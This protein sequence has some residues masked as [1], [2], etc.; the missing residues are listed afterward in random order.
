[1]T[2]QQSPGAGRSSGHNPEV[3][4]GVPPRNTNFTGREE[5]LEKL[6]RGIAEEV[7]AVVPQA[8]HG[9][10]GV[11][12]TLLAAE[13]AYRYRGEY[14]LV[15]WIPADQ[16]VLVRSS[17]AQLAPHLGLPPFTLTGIEESARSVLDAL[18][19]GEP[20]SRWLLVFDNAD[21]PEDLNDILPRGP[22]HVL[23]TSR[24]HRWEGVVDTLPVEVFTRKESVAFLQKRVRQSITEA[25][26]TR[27]ADQ[28]GDLPL[29]LEQAGALMAETGMTVAEYIRLLGEHTRLVLSEGK[30]PEYPTSMSAAWALSVASVGEK[31]PE[32][33][34]VLRYCAYFSPDAIPRRVFSEAKPGLSPQLP[35]LIGNPLRVSKIIWELGRYALL[36]VDPGT[37]SIQVHRLI[38]A[39]V[40]DELLSDEK[41]K[42]RHDVHLLLAGAVPDDPE[43]L[44][45]WPKY[46]ELVGHIAPSGAIECT[47]ERLHTTALNMVRY[48]YLSGQYVAARSLDEEILTTWSERA[49]EDNIDVLRAYR[50]LAIIMRG[51]GEYAAA[52]QLNQETLKKLQRIPGSDAEEEALLLVNSIGA[53]LRANGDFP[54]AKTHDELSRAQHESAFGPDDV[55]TLRA[56]HNLALDYGMTSDYEGARDLH[57]E[58]YQR[59]AMAAA[60][61][62]RTFVLSAMTGTSRATRLCGDYRR[63]C[64]L[65]EDAYA[66][67]VREMGA[68]HPLTLRAAIELSVGRRRAADYD[69]AL[70]LAEAAYARLN[71]LYG[72]DNPDTMAAAICLAN[73]LRTRGDFT[74]AL[75]LAADSMPR[76]QDRFGSEHPY[77]H[78]CA[79]NLALLKRVTG[80]PANARKL[81]EEALAGLEAK[82]TRDHHFSLTVAT[83]LASDLAALGELEAAV[84]LG[85]GNLR[86]LRALFDLDHPIV[87]ASSVNLA[88]DLR[89]LGEE[90]EA[91]ELYADAMERYERTIGLDHPDAVVAAEGRHLD[92]DFDPP[93][94]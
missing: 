78:A 51:Q 5:L 48:L 35:G 90:K 32:A 27:L 39:L 20:Y 70:D 12:K 62:G 10:G 46:A 54:A 53:D 17:L 3:W 87:L 76:Y 45:S 50:H 15:W 80:E 14:D 93:P 4:G 92:F 84:R 60:P 56:I 68:D 8:L 31:L 77:C 89:A 25:D 61:T 43:D 88:V 81:D 13:Y 40:R 1:M 22:G 65:G 79:G 73:I 74:A 59:Q 86:R 16:P 66:Y 49:G 24:N 18:R 44:E 21:Q 30:P 69:G 94:I 42:V 58:T 72:P 7:T 34:A 11:G 29:A 33:V 71:R 47:D 26:A 75:S 82:L 52:T 28:L 38:Q 9:L 2:L 57:E 41:D 67:A 55:R 83:N 91:E 63:A 85:R 23:I 19:R 36:R 37:S 6:R 64:E